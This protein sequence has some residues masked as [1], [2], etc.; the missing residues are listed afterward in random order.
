[1]HEFDHKIREKL[2]PAAPE[3]RARA[4]GMTEEVKTMYET[5]RRRAAMLSWL[6]TGVGLWLMI[7]GIVAL[8]VGVQ[9]GDTA[10]VVIGA[11][12]FLFG[13]GWITGS[14]L[15]YWVWQSRLQLQRDLKEMH[16]DVLRL[17]ERLDRLETRP[18]EGDGN[19][20]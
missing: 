1:M 14:K 20:A 2:L 12:M 9:F 17:A 7:L 19:C 8:I 13:D 4:R 16:V 3:W 18:A 10:V 11:I 15:L 6:G 5:K